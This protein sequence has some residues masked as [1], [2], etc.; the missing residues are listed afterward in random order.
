MKNKSL[1]AK[2]FKCCNCGK[3]A[4][5]FWPVCDP[6]IESHPYCR[7]CV[8]EAKQ[9]LFIEFAKIDKKYAK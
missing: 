8:D 3:K 6:D 4:V 9:R 1:Q 5:C 2:D 7:K